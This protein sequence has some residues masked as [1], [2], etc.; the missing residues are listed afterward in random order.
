MSRRFRVS[1][2]WRFVTK[3]VLLPPLN[4]LMK[5]DWRGRDNL[6]RRG[7]AIIA[8]NHISEVDPLAVAHY[9][10]KCGRWPSFMIKDSV[11]T[12]PVLGSI[13]TRVGQIP[14]SRGTSAAA[15]SLRRAEEALAAGALVV[16]Y[17]EGTCTRDPQLWPMV[18][19]TGVARLALA[20]GAPV[21]PLA[22]FGAQQ[23]LPYGAKR[24][25]LLPRKTMRILAGPPVDLSRYADAPAEPATYR[26]VTDAVMADVTGLVAQLRGEP[27]PARPYDPRVGRS[28]E[29]SG[30]GTAS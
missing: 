10:Y 25:D 18:G 12:V 29:T 21:I 6:P 23:I 9:F 24:P 14:V 5:R 26:A 13:L 16:V 4:T 19:K 1:P 17:P 27:A 15:G 7:G 28:D 20:S 11:F 3:C 8:L 22:V 30:G 2:W